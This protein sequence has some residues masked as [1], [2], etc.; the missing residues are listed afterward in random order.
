[1]VLSWGKNTIHNLPNTTASPAPG[2]PDRPTTP[3]F[4]SSPAPSGGLFGSSSTAAPSTT[5]GLFGSS[6][7]APAAGGLFG[8]S[9]PATSS[10]GLF[11]APAPSSGGLFGSTPASTGGLFGSPAPATGSLFGAAPSTGGGLFG[12]APSSGGLFGSSSNTGTSLFGAPAP[13]SGGLFGSAPNQLQHQQSQRAPL[14]AQAALQAHLDAS[15]RQEEARVQEQLSTLYQSYQGTQPGSSKKSAPFTTTVYQ[16]APVALIQQHGVQTMGI[17]AGKYDI[18]LSSLIPQPP[19]FS[20]EDWHR[21]VAEIPCDD[22]A[23]IP[24]PLVSGAALLTRAVHHDSAVKECVSQVSTLEDAAKFIQLRQDRARE[25]LR[26]LKHRQ[27]QLRRKMLHVLRVVD[28]VRTWNQPSTDSN[29]SEVAA[30]RRL[31]NVGTELQQLHSQLQQLQRIPPP[32]P[33]EIRDIPAD[34]VRLKQTMTEHRQALLHVMDELRS[35]KTTVDCIRKAP[36][37]IQQS[38]GGN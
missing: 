11:G 20:E 6:T 32:A 34:E 27:E 4:G 8:S 10:A 1:M 24:V 17:T 18:P 38:V 19:Q 22:P 36:M 14:P 33:I 7:P 25:Q 2:A 35:A 31:H 21:A 12:S 23:L 9:A 30:A 26:C 37:L 3:A 15:A 16:E 5:G 13:A 28:L 29:A